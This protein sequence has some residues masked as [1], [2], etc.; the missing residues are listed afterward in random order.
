MRI[1]LRRTVR[2]TGRRR[3]RNWRWR[4]PS[5]RLALAGAGLLLLD[6]H[7]AATIDEMHELL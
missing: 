6:R 1:S 7:A 5:E 4:A 2:P 3:Q